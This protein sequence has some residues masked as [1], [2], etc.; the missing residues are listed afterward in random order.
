MWQGG[1]N[2]MI[3]EVLF[4]PGH[5]MILKL[6]IDLYEICQ[7]WQFV[8]YTYLL[9]FCKQGPNIVQ[10]FY[11]VRTQLVSMETIMLSQTECYD[12]NCEINKKSLGTANQQKISTFS[13]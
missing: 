7:Q 13:L 10:M 8:Q 9:V 12:F 3:F 6:Y 2:S 11:L 5:S 4:N 1:W